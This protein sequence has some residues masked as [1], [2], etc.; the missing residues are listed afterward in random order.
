MTGEDS[1]AGLAASQELLE[2]LERSNLFLVPLDDEGCWYRYHHLFADML[3]HRLRQTLPHRV[4]DLHERASVWFERQ[5]SQEEAIGHAI[6]A[7]G[8][9]RAELHDS[10][11]V[12]L[13]EAKGNRARLS[14]TTM[15]FL[16]DV[17]A[18]NYV[19]A[20]A[21]TPGD[22]KSVQVPLDFVLDALGEWQ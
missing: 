3:R 19:K 10:A 15:D 11:L 8:Y 18:F 1:V 6:A 7:G 20:T 5:G 2:E 17:T 14:N 16:V 9:D 12:D 21:T 13:L 4:S 22:R